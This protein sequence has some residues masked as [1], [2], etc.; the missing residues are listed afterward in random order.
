MIQ[1]PS[2]AQVQGAPFREGAGLTDHQAMEL[3]MA[4]CDRITTTALDARR[5][6]LTAGFGDGHEACKFLDRVAQ[7]AT[8]LFMEARRIKINLPV[9]RANTEEVNNADDSPP[10]DPG[11]AATKRGGAR[12]RDRP[13]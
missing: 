12:R 9:Q 8:N 11:A 10:A 1:Q 4:A 3:A 2:K 13:T 5:N 6:L 7:E